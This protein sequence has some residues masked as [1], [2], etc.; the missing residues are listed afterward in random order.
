MY[1]TNQIVE[2]EF[3]E[4]FSGSLAEYDITEGTGGYDPRPYI[5]EFILTLRKEDIEAHCEKVRGMKIIIENEEWKYKL[6]S[7]RQGEVTGYNTALS[8]ILSYF[9]SLL[10][11]TGHERE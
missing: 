5:K 1:K 3:D 6:S 8:D 10:S 2:K 7:E 4:K 9:E 11:D